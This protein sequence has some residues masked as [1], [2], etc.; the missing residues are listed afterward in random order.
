MFQRVIGIFLGA[1][2]RFRRWR[3]NR[4]SSAADRFTHI[5]VNGHWFRNGETR[6]GAGSTFVATQEFR[7]EL[8]KL[9][10]SLDCKRLLDLGCGD[11]NWM[12]H[13]QLPCDYLGA[14]I[15]R[16]LIESNNREHASGRVQFV[17]MNGSTDPIPEGCDV[18]LCREVLFYISFADG[19]AM[20]SNIKKSGANYLLATQIATGRPN[21]DIYTGGYRML[22][23]RQ[24]PFNFPEP[25]MSIPDDR[26]SKLRSLDVWRV[27]DLP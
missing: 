10:R 16:S 17:D 25:V 18:I 2:V 19:M 6:S 14:D 26:V 12:K 22:D 4:L 7:I 5:Y 1:G 21:S 11:F 8:P 13:V 15:V 27:A 9:L 24:E 23:L 3:I 20:V